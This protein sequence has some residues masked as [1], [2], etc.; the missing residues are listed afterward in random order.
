MGLE[1]IHLDKAVRRRGLSGLLASSCSRVRLLRVSPVDTKTL[2]SATPKTIDGR[3]YP[4]YLRPFERHDP[5]LLQL[6]ER[7]Q[8]VAFD[9]LSREIGDPR[10]QAILPQW[11]A[12][13]EWRGKIERIDPT[14]HSPRRYR[15]GPCAESKSADGE[16]PRQLRGRRQISL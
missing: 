9:Q 11:L 6:V 12:S 1:E 16:V 3:S 7:L 4:D 14:L 13:A 10:Q 8:P 5:T 2:G 15:L